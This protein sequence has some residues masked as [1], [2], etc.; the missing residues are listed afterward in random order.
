MASVVLFVSSV[1]AVSVEVAAV[2]VAIGVSL[3]ISA[4]TFF[5]TPKPKVPSLNQSLTDRTQN[6]REPVSARQ[7]IYGRIRVGGVV[8]LVESSSTNNEFLHIILSLAGHPVEAIE[9]IFFDDV[10]VPLDD[11]GLATGDFAGLVQIK[12]GLGTVGGD[13]DFNATLQANIPTIWTE[14]HKQTG[15]A[16]LYIRLKFD[17]DKFSSIPVITC[18]VRGKKVFDPRDSVTRW[19]SNASLCLRD[20]L[21]DTEIGFGE[22]DANIN[23][24]DWIAE[25]NICEEDVPLLSQTDTFTVDDTT[26]IVT[27]DT[28]PLAISALAVGNLVRLTTTG[29][30]PTGLSLSTDYYWI[31]IRAGVGMLASSKAN[32]FAWTAIDITDTGTG[33]HTIDRQDELRYLCDGLIRTDTAHK[34]IIGDLLSSCGGRIT[35]QGGQWNMLTASFRSPTVSYDEEDTIVPL[36]I[37]ALTTRRELINAARGV[38]SDSDNNWKA[39]DFPAVKNTTYFNEDLFERLWADLQFNFTASSIAAQRMAK[40]EVERGRQQIAFTLVVDLRG[41]LNKAGDVINYSNS[42]MGWTNKQFE[43]ARWNGLVFE[44]VDGVPTPSVSMDLRETASGIFDWVQ[45]EE[46]KVDL[47]PN[48]NLPSPNEVGEPEALLL[49]SGTDQLFVGNDGTVISRILVTWDAPTGEFLIDGYEVEFKKS[50]EASWSTLSTSHE[51]RRLFI[52]PVQDGIDYDVRVRSANVTGAKSGYVQELGHTVT[53]KSAP[54]SKPDSFTVGEQADGTRRYSWTHSNPEPDVRSGGGYKIRWFLGTTTSWSAMTELHNGV[55][56]SS[57]Y[58]SNELASGTYTFAI[59]SV[60]SS[61]NESTDAI[62][63][64]S[65]PLQNP[66]IANAILQRNEKTLE[67]SGSLVDC[68]L[69]N[70]N[71]LSAIA[72]GQGWADLPSTWAG[73]A[74]TWRGINNR[75]SPIAYVTEMIDLGRDFNIKPLVTLLAEGVG[76][77]RVLT[78]TDADGGVVLPEEK[79][80]NSFFTTDLASWTDADTGTGVSAWNSANS[81]SMRLNGGASGE[82][83]RHQTISDLVVDEIYIVFVLT[84]DN[85]CEITIDGTVLG[86]EAN[87][88]KTSLPVGVNLFTFFAKTTSAIVSFS[89]A[90]N[91]DAD[92]SIVALSGLA[93]AELV[94]ARYIQIAGIVTGTTPEIKE[95]I[96]VIDSPAVV[97]EFDD[98]VGASSTDI[99]FERV[100]AGNYKFRTKGGISQITQ[101]SITAIQNSGAGFSSELVSKDA[102]F[103]PNLVANPL[104]TVDLASWT[105]GNTGTG[106]SIWVAAN[107]GSMQLNGGASGVGARYQSIGSLVVGQRYKVIIF[108]HTNPIG[109]SVDETLGDGAMYPLTSLT[110]GFHIIFFTATATTAILYFENTNN[111]NR[112]VS[113]VVMYD[114]QPTAEFNIY[115]SSGVLADATVDVRLRGARA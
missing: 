2:I 87:F 97:E 86:D 39:D 10:L 6:I 96:T 23:D 41:M 53:G 113:I 31:P 17:R 25:A 34:N 98:I 85:L 92:V 18:V 69:N 106:T 28:D 54:P 99:N 33:V 64:S 46:T 74:S 61:G 95:M 84:H 104:L 44:D 73:L 67:W 75:K 109:F 37:Q 12:K 4:V 58:E 71:Q 63:I 110:A 13:G 112:E 62:F 8:T 102:G 115:N 11:D 21:T 55:L 60:D 50:G 90:N 22:A 91:N 100:S 19:S 5:L 72:D 35:Y 65:V 30:L 70:E 111:D 114:G 40:I 105:S 20:Y 78:G 1:L 107:S 26:D 82:A 51:G 59:K 48:T 57:P 16:K 45:G 27:L 108:S 56:L 38:F 9:D 43:I 52:Q 36:Q 93:E 3:A 83:V 79:L 81:G 14:D 101:A 80:L 88:A 42:K 103:G 29:T 94:T 15:V 89:N 24:V 66:R 7:I 49:Q 76:S 32:A 68:F 47:A 77:V